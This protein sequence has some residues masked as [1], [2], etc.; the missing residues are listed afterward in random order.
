MKA[1]LKPAWAPLNSL[2]GGEV[3]PDR[4]SLPADRATPF[5]PAKAQR[6]PKTNPR[7]NQGRGMYRRVVFLGKRRKTSHLGEGYPEGQRHNVATGLLGRYDSGT[8]DNK[9]VWVCLF[10]RDPTTV[11]LPF[12]F[13]S[14][15]IKQGVPQKRHQYSCKCCTF[16]FIADMQFAR[17]GS[18]RDRIKDP[19]T[20][21]A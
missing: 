15:S 21:D 14:K 11:V 3:A 18:G 20:G 5:V 9:P 1:M 7:P 12:G 6:V 17:R 2:P 16:S 13:P 4:S 8:L 19:D 10:W